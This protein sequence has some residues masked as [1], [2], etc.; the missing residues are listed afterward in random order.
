MQFLNLPPMFSSEPQQQPKQA[1]LLKLIR[2][3]APLPPMVEPLI[4]ALLPDD[5]EIVDVAEQFVAQSG[6]IYDQFISACKEIL[7]DA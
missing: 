7:A 6:P 1:A 5:Q 2:S 4:Q 3:F